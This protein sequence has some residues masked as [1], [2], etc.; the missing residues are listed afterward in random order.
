MA[1]GNGRGDGAA[2][3]AVAV[4]GI[5]AAALGAYWYF[6]LRKKCPEGQIYDEVTKKCIPGTGGGGGGGG[7]TGLTVRSM[8]GANG[9]KGERF[10]YGDQDM[11]LESTSFCVLLTNSTAGP[12]RVTYLGLDGSTLGEQVYQSGERRTECGIKRVVNARPDTGGGASG[13]LPVVC[14]G[15]DFT[16]ECVPAGVGEWPNL[17]AF[18]GKD[19]DDR[20]SSIYLPPVASDGSRYA[21]TLYE[22]TYYSGRLLE[23][24][25][26][27]RDLRPWTFDN[28][29]SSMKVRK[30]LPPGT[31]AA[32]GG[33]CS[34]PTICVDVAGG[35]CIAGTGCSGSQ[36]CCAPQPLA[37]A[38][39]R[40]AASPARTYWDLH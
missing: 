26:S 25:V 30:V 13:P 15:T 7:G 40:R 31:C 8:L 38:S 2:V 34:N 23:F 29:A 39:G 17:A 20:I 37:N 3:A 19:W 11:Y 6:V 5:G 9:G 35:R 1:N 36:C 22:G 4:V 10:P 32:A 27:D 33:Q 12:V 18:Q 24:I 16:G 14:E 28:I 21:V